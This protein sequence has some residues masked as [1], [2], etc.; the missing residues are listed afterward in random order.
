MTSFEGFIYWSLQD[1]HNLPSLVLDKVGRGVHVVPSGLSRYRYD[2]RCAGSLAI[3]PLACFSVSGFGTHLCFQAL[4]AARIA[5]RTLHPYTAFLQEFGNCSRP[6]PQKNA[7]FFL[8]RKGQ[9]R[10]H[11]L[12]GLIQL[13][14]WDRL[15]YAAELVQLHINPPQCLRVS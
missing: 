4:K 9:R 8:T 13:A 12:H 7:Q 2:Q 5:L 15:H 6:H 3:F 11:R 1:P 14:S 10:G